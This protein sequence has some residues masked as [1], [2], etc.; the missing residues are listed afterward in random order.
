M[1]LHPLKIKI[2]YMAYETR[3]FTP[4][5]LNIDIYE[6]SCLQNLTYFSRQ[7][8]SLV[9]KFGRQSIHLKNRKRKLHIQ[10]ASNRSH[11]QL[12]DKIK[13]IYSIWFLCQPLGHYLPAFASPEVWILI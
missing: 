3:L 6:I 12:L 11:H 4:N 13:C 2:L 8:S 5:L 9:R 7:L 1:T 10:M